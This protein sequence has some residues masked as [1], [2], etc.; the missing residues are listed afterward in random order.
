[1]N[2]KNLAINKNILLICSICKSDDKISN[3]NCIVCNRPVHALD[4]C[5]KIFDSEDTYG[6]QRICISC[7]NISKND[8]LHAIDSNQV[9]NWRNLTVKSTKKKSRYL[10]KNN[11]CL[12]LEETKLKNIPILQNGNNINFKA[13]NIKGKKI[14]L[15][16]TCAFDSIY[17]IFLV[18]LFQSEDF[19]TKVIEY[20][21]KNMF[22]QLIFDTFSK[23]LSKNTY[24]SRAVILS[25]IFEATET[26]NNCF[27]INCKV[28]VGYLCKQ[29]FNNVPSFKE[30]TSCNKCHDMREKLFPTI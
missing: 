25:D 30:L 24:Y 27:L 26:L 4:T 29:L 22:F 16:Q 8:I 12:D 10:D 23:D 1:L 17:Q 3:H 19:K 7:Q 11:I 5:S 20:S 2:E 6:T 13:I 21:N 18:A 28:S 15:I 14:S 9:E